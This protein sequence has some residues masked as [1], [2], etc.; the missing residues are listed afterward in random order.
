MGW[1]ALGYDYSVGFLPP[2]PTMLRF[3]NE[4]KNGNGLSSQTAAPSC[5][6]LRRNGQTTSGA[7]WLKPLDDQP[8]IKVFCDMLR[9]D[10]GWTLVYKIAGHSA[11]RTN[12][13]ENVSGLARCFT[14]VR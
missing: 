13:E 9:D 6:V 5:A 3:Q 7:Y 11:M 12:D 1:N 14:R 4:Q 8:A 2:S 10:G